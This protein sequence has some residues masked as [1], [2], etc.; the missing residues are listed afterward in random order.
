MARALLF[1]G[2]GDPPVGRARGPPMTPSTT[3]Q[4]SARLRLIRLIW[5]FV[6]IVLLL[7][8]IGTTSLEVIRG[9]RAYITAESAWSNAQNAAIEAL[10]QYAQ[11]RNEDHYDRYIDEARV[12]AGARAARIEL[13]KPFPDFDVARRSLLQARNHPADIDGMINLFRRFRPVGFMAGGVQIWT[14]AD[15]LFA[16]IE[17][18][19][20]EIHASIRSGRGNAGDL[21]PALGE[22]RGLDRSLTARERAFYA[23]FATTARQIE[24]ALMIVTLGLG[25]ALVL[26]AIV[27]TQRLIRKEDA[28]LAALRASQQRFD[29]VVSGTNDGIWDWSLERRDLYCSPRFEQLLGYA[30]GML[31][32]TAGTFLRRIHAADRRPRSRGCASTSFA[33]IRSISSSACALPTATTGGSRPRPLRSGSARQAAADGRLAGGHLDRKRAEAQTLQEKERAQVT[34]ASIADAVITVDT[35]GNVEYMNPI[36]ERLTGFANDEAHGFRCHPCSVQDEAT[37]IA[38]ADPSG[39]P[40]PRRSPSRRKATSCC[41]V[42]MTDRSPS[43]TPPPRSATAPG[44]SAASCSCSTT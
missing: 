30:P 6:A 26:V 24:T 32:E 12:V 23:T 27:R 41:S 20:Q 38:I 13:E 44:A 42:A 37:G 25:V 16:R 14:D 11:T 40:A 18:I 31:R 35:S 5:P 22:M 21:E 17:A 2:R 15:A 4:Q 19:A 29:Y 10:E 33:A 7:L 1:P 34:L 9:V 39:A 36:A 43:I 28:F 3:T 8:A